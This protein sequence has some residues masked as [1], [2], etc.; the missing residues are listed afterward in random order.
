MHTAKNILNRENELQ[1]RGTI[2]E[3]KKEVNDDVWF[4]VTKVVI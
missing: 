1:K 2:G 4:N 3:G